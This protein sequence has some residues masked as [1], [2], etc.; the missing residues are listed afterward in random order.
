MRTGRTEIQEKLLLREWW[1]L[2]S[3]YC[4]TCIQRYKGCECFCT[5]HENSNGVPCICP[6]NPL[7]QMIQSE[8]I[9]PGADFHILK[10][11]VSTSSTHWCSL[12]SGESS[13]PVSPEEDPWSRNPKATVSIDRCLFFRAQAAIYTLHNLYFFIAHLKKRL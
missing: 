1:I 5:R 7:F 8:S 11:N 4:P 3:I 12:N 13:I 9:R 2:R 10:H 6:N